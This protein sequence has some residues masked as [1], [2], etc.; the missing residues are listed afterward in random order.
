MQETID[1]I[2]TFWFGNGSTAEEICAEKKALWWA[3]DEETDREITSRFRDVVQAVHEGRLDHWRETPKGLLASIICCDQFPRNMYRGTPRA[4]EFDPVAL[5]MAEQILATG[6]HLELSPIQ[7]VFA[8]LPFEHSEDPASQDK[9][10]R[11]FAD[12]VGE[13][14][15]SEREIFTGFLDF[16][17]R[18]E[19][20]IARF[21]R[22]P[23]R[24]V[25]LGR[26]SS[27]EETEFLT[28]PGSS[29]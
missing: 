24:N 13:V 2:L 17:R 28:Q 21:G 7:R 14:D 22:F 18:H 8:Y 25:I 5:G 23:H 4:F 29:F 10:V 12:L 20:I 1:S 6:D 3:K 11:L 9:A 16:A 19:E 15:A 26:E 27:D